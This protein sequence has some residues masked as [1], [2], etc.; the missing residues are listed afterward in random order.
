MLP[1]YINLFTI[2]FSVYHLA[3]KSTQ[4]SLKDHVFSLH[5]K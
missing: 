4:T 2:V 3:L 5:S 1:P